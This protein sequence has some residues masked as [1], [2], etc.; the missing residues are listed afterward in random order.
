MN[1]STYR[2]LP[3]DKVYTYDHQPGTICGQDYVEGT[4]EYIKGNRAHI[5]WDD[6]KETDEILTD[7]C[8]FAISDEH[9]EETSYTPIP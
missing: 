6:G 4:V 8:I 1:Q 5:K 9:Y 7:D 2:P 3:G